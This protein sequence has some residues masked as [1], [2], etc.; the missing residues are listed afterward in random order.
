VVWSDR[1]AHFIGDMPHTWVGSDF[2]RSALD[3]FAYTRESDR[4]VVLAAG[5]PWKW[6]ARDSGVKV[7][8]LPTPYGKVAYSLRAFSDSLEVKIEEGVQAPGGIVV[9]VPAAPKMPW[10]HATLDGQNVDMKKPIIV[11]RLPAVLIYAP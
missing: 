3:L 6:V 11:R 8:E 4:T 2:V 7:R 9:N 1:K 10:K 5:I